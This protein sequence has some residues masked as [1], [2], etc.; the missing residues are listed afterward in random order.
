M[1]SVARRPVEEEVARD[2]STRARSRRSG[3]LLLRMPSELH[4]DLSRLAE[5]DGVSL[6]QLIVRTLSESLGVEGDPAAGPERRPQR[7]PRLLGV[8]LVANLV[9][10]AL[11]GVAAVALLV[12]AWFAGF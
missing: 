8:A 1:G 3:R 9:V 12:A 6:N 5:R 4:D 11:A 7:E 10:V 2:A